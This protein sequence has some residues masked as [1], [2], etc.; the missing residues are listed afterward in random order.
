MQATALL[1]QF[2]LDNHSVQAHPNRVP[3]QK[4]S[5]K[6]KRQSHIYQR[7]ARRTGNARSLQLGPIRSQ[8]ITARQKILRLQDTTFTQPW[9]TASGQPGYKLG[10]PTPASVNVARDNVHFLLITSGYAVD[11]R[12]YRNALLISGHTHD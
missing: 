9:C 5:Q 4:S 1:L 3:T 8:V 10:I 11:G 6:G 7:A 2:L 12:E